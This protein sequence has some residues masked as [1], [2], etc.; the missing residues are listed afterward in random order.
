MPSVTMGRGQWAVLSVHLPGLPPE[1]V[2]ILLS[3][4]ADRLYVRTRRQWYTVAGYEDELDICRQVADE[5]KQMGRE[6]PASEVLDW[7]ENTASHVLRIGARHEVQ[8]VDTDGTLD[9]L[10]R[11]HLATLPHEQIRQGAMRGTSPRMY[12]DED[13]SAVPKRLESGWLSDHRFQAALAAGFILLSVL[14]GKRT[15]VGPR[16]PLDSGTVMHEL[17]ALSMVSELPHQQLMLYIEPV[18]T[19]IAAGHG[20]SPIKR[21]AGRF[22]KRLQPRSIALQPIPRQSVQIPPPPRDIAIEMSS[23]TFLYFDL[24]DL[25]SFPER[26][27]RII[28]FLSAIASPFQELFSRCRRLG[29]SAFD[30]SGRGN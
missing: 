19:P 4:T 21:N 28:R 20:H 29:E 8:F 17:N 15:S 11:Q 2:G 7:L 25:P 23:P 5:L 12:G 10:C 22:H 13:K 6:L 1:P 26:R 3:D 14:A 9:S 30:L 24:P 27:R 18:Q 16:L